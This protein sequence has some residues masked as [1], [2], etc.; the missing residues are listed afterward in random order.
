MAKHYESVGQYISDFP[1]N[2]QKRL[3][4]VRKFI[5]KQVPESEE[6]ISYNMPAYTLNGKRFIYFSAYKK[7][8]SLYPFP[9]GNEELEKLASNLNYVTSGKG[10]IQFQNDQ[11]I[12]WDIV[13]KII[14]NNVG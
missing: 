7:H 11:E 5:K 14:K 4:E 10:T 2:V 6:V 1:E 13:K 9:D 3:Q 12:D 8:I